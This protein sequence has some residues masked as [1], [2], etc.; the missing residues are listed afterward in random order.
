MSG[1]IFLKSMLHSDCSIE[2]LISG[3]EQSENQN[4]CSAFIYVMQSLVSG[5]ITMDRPMFMNQIIHLF[6][7]YFSQ[8]M[9]II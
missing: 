9:L 2:L 7:P 1:M 3:S 5:L 6:I 8:N 4:Q